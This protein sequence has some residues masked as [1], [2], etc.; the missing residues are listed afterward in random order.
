LR[1]L[2]FLAQNTI[3]ARLSD[4]EV[5]LSHPANFALHKLLILDRRPMSEKQTKDKESALRILHALV[6]RGEGDLLRAVFNAMPHRWQAKV[7]KRLADALDRKIRDIL[8]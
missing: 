1:F 2:D 6:D 7:C 5:T 3:T 4:I 8:Q